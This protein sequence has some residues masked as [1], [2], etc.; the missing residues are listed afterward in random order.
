MYFPVSQDFAVR[1]SFITLYLSFLII[2]L[3]GLY[4]FIAKK[5]SI[6]EP[7][8]I[9][10]VFD[11]FCL[12][13]APL[14]FLILGD[15][16]CH[17]TNIIG[18]CVEGTF[19]HLL[20]Y[21]SF[22]LGMRSERPS[23]LDETAQ[24]EVQPELLWYFKLFWIISFALSMIF[25]IL[26]GKSIS[27]VFTLGYKGTVTESIQSD[28]PIKFLINVSYCMLPCWLMIMLN[29]N[30][31][32]G[33][34]LYT[35][36][37]ACVYLIRGTRFIIVLMFLSYICC[38]YKKNNKQIKK[39]YFVGAVM[40]VILYSVITQ[41]SRGS[42]RS[43]TG[44]NLEGF[45]FDYIYRVLEANFDI[46]K[47]Y[48]GIVDKVPE[49]VPYTYGSAMLLSPF[50]YVV[51]RILWRAKPSAATMPLIKSMIEAVGSK[52][53]IRAGMST[54]WLTEVY[55]DF[56]WLGAIFVPLIYGKVLYRIYC[57]LHK[58][59]IFTTQLVSY[60]IVYAG[61]MQCIMRGYTAMNC[62][63][64]VFLLLPIIVMKILKR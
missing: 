59:K 7:F 34:V 46:Y 30:N 3:H 37:T 31:R 58:N 50:I 49:I 10:F 62:W 4:V 29:S 5:I 2:S 20:A 12:V 57:K 32:G 44:I 24:V 22:Y 8:A 55:L 64:Y 47:T 54:V 23:S 28:T 21:F 40:I 53:I 25:L 1:N 38:Y 19:F 27:Y 42:L 17:G 13:I 16:D 41:Y 26:D 63:M 43:G 14:I 60:S 18:G 36:F 61:I 48:Y 11:Y 52:A 39:I 56:G 35:F 6:F 51:P 33:K 45:T 9:F 15:T